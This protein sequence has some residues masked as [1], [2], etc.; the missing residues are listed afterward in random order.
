M[1]SD[2]L[3]TLMLATLISIPAIGQD[4]N[5]TTS[6]KTPPAT[7]SIAPASPAP[8]LFDGKTLKN[9]KETNFGGSGGASVVDGEI[10]IEM[11]AELS[12]ITFT[13]VSSLPQT[14]YEISLEAMKR[15]GTDFFCGLTF[16]VGTNHCSLIVGGWGGGLVGI[17]SIDGM[18]ASE[19][20]TTKYRSFDKNKWYKI[21]VR[22]TPEKITTWLDD[23]QLIDVEIKGRKVSMRFGDIEQSTPLGIAT[24]QT[25]ASIRNLQLKRL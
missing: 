9:W 19:N 8:T 12:G 14:N 3:L 15:S 23:E 13:N 10:R 17:S 5:K 21:R 6:P 4:T 24:Y 18:D 11:G 16:P 20:E 2:C 1:K 22:V 7:G 25:S